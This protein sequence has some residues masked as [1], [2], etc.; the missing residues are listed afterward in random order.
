MFCYIA[1]IY[2]SNEEKVL[3]RSTHADVGCLFSM[4]WR[5]HYNNSQLLCCYLLLHSK[6]SYYCYSW[7]FILFRFVFELSS[8]SFSYTLHRKNGLWIVS[9]QCGVKREKLM[10]LCES[11]AKLELPLYTLTLASFYK[12][13]NL[14]SRSRNANDAS[15]FSKYHTCHTWV[16]RLESWRIFSII[17][18]NSYKLRD[19]KLEWFYIG[20]LF[21]YILSRTILTEIS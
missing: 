4:Y 7:K 2:I 1:S 6:W 18:P 19:R 13:K 20:H 14:H 11:G 17:M 15:H 9:E 21:P 5:G 16:F 12:K 8:T 3:F 10:A